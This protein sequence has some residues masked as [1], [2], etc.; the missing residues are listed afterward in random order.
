MWTY[1]FMG[2]DKGGMYGEDFGLLL[3]NYMVSCPYL[4]NSFVAKYFIEI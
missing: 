4:S 1:F 3:H 2:K